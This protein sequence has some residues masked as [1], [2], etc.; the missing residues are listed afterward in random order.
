M[1]KENTDFA[2]CLNPS[3]RG[4]LWSS[5]KYELC[6]AFSAWLKF[7]VQT[8]ILSGAFLVGPKKTPSTKKHTSDF[9]M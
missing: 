1:V 7:Y 9:L 2:F 8:D 6:F 5:S 3:K 4:H